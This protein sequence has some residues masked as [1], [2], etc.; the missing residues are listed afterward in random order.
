MSIKQFELPGRKCLYN[1]NAFNRILWTTV[2]NN[3]NGF[4]I[5]YIFV[6]IFSLNICFNY[7]R[8]DGKTYGIQS[9]P[10]VTRTTMWTKARALFEGRRK[11]TLWASSSINDKSHKKVIQDKDMYGSR[12][13]EFFH[14]LREWE[15]YY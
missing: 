4:W 14:F 9:P 1:Y 6:W 5:N 11:K 15:R 13:G 12:M 10:I 3:N 2:N 7:L 8:E